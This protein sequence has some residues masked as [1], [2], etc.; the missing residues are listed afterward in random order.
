MS[1]RWQYKV[2]QTTQWMG[3]NPKKLEELIA[4]LGQMG[5]E[6]VSVQCVAASTIFYLKKP[7]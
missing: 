7:A 3:V 6:L 2:V 4:P 5:W 1:V